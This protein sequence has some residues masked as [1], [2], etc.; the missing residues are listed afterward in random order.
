LQE[1]LVALVNASGSSLERGLATFAYLGIYEGAA[2]KV[3][4]CEE[5]AAATQASYKR[6][7]TNKAAQQQKVSRRPHCTQ[8]QMMLCQTQRVSL[9]IAA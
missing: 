9:S 7:I 2:E 8:Q 3:K 6:R 5:A 1:E 4:G